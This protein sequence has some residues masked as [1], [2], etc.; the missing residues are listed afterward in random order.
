MAAAL[1]THLNAALKYARRGWPVFP[2]HT[3]KNGV[4]SC[5]DP[6]TVDSPG[7]HPRTLHGQ[8]EATTDE[9]QIREWWTRWPDAGIATIPGR[10][11]YVV[12]D[13]DGPEALLEAQQLGL[14]AEPTLEVVTG[15]DGGR[16][17]WCLR[18]AFEVS[19]RCGNLR[20]LHIR[21]DKGYVLLPPSIH[22]NGKR[23]RWR[24]QDEA[25][26]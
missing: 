7:K 8:N 25:A 24:S 23:Y 5:G 2:T 19:N 16:H 3:A 9:A 4:C 6:C 12:F 17:L 26:V 11:G 20:Y 22:P 13:I 15:R 1:R 14:L 18:P 10:C 21:G